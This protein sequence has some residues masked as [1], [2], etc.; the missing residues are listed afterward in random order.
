MQNRKEHTTVID[1]YGRYSSAITKA[2][3]MM[4]TLSLVGVISVCHEQRANAEVT[5]FSRDV[6]D[7]ID[8]GI[9]W[10]DS[11]GVF[12]NPAGLS[13]PD[14]NALGLAALSIM[15]R[16]V[17]ADQNAA[18]AGYGNATAED[19]VR[20]QSLIT[21]IINRATNASF[22]AYRDGGDL[23]AI[24]LYARTGGPSQADAITAIN[25]I[26]DRMRS[27]QGSHGY[28]AYSGPGTDSSTTQ[29]VVAGLAGARAVFSDQRF[30]DPVRLG[31]LNTMTSTTANAY[32]TRSTAGDLTNDGRG[33]GYSPTHAPSFQQTASGLWSQIIG[34]YDLNSQSVQ[35][36]LKWL[37]LRYNYQTIEPYRNSWP[38]AHL[39]YM[40]SSAKAYTFLED[41]GA[42]AA[43]GNLDTQDLGTLPSN[44]A[45][46]A[47]VR[48][49]HRDPSAD[50]RVTRRGPEGAGYY[51]SIHELPR[52]YYDYAYTLMGLQDVNGRFV[53]NLNSW[54]RIA[55][56]SYA[57]L[58]LERSVGGGCVDSDNDDACDA[59]DNC[60]ALPN[61]DQLDADNDGIGDLCDA[62]PQN[63]DPN[64]FDTDGDGQ[65]DACDVCPDLPNPDQEDVDG[66]GVGDLCDNCPAEADRSQADQDSDGFGDVCD[67]CPEVADPN[68]A[69][70]D[71][72]G[73]GNACDLCIA[74]PDPSQS[75]LDED[76]VGDVCDNCLLVS[77]TDQIDDDRD[78]VGD[79]CDMCVGSSGPEICDGID[80]DC[81]NIVDEDPLLSARC[82]VPGGGSCGVGIP[83]CVD[84]G[85]ICE[86]LTTAQDELC[87]GLDDDCDGR[88]DEM[89]IDEGQ[90]CF[91]DQPGSCST[92]LSRCVDGELACDPAGSPSDEVCDLIDSD[93]DGFIDEGT[94]NQCGLCGDSLA[95]VCDGLDQDCDGVVD[96]SAPCEGNL[97][98]FA[99]ECVNTCDSNECFGA[100]VCVDGFCVDP[101]QTTECNADQVCRGGECIDPCEEVTCADNEACYLG[102]CRRDSCFEI[103]CPEG[104]RCGPAGC[105]ND[106]CAEVVC[107][108]NSFCRD[109]VCIDSCGIISCP[110]DEQCVDGQCV[111]NPCSDIVCGAGEECI[112]GSC[113]ESPCDDVSCEEGYVCV[114][115][116]CEF[117]GC[118]NIECPPGERCEI[119]VDGDA[120][121]VGDWTDPPP[122]EEL[123]PPIGNGGAEEAGMETGEPTSDNEFT[124]D[125]PPVDELE[126]MGEGGAESVSGCQQSHSP[127]LPALFLALGIA[128]IVIRR[129]SEIL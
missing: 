47:N 34:G 54:N 77:N 67:V 14:R 72:D 60:P 11:I 13:G 6:S 12:N 58:V 129:R 80:N 119:N 66:D 24:S 16:R 117:N 20:I 125:I 89:T 122:P 37:Y 31:Q 7:A 57:M 118:E 18:S 4:L 3:S 79:A 26:F 25:N 78:G 101:C 107:E 123:E 86:P 65:G 56:H 52:W 32:A 21:Y 64:Q 55:S 108:A 43:P 116:D 95:E 30:V 48:L 15:E 27:G 85:V 84:G 23:M 75:D 99:G 93:C 45:P 97:T 105:E 70:G 102:E 39:Y 5:N 36:Y 35:E 50:P 51:N 17:S 33:H 112:N 62:C 19:Q 109:G 59:E 88:L 41:S 121:C 42:V 46:S 83:R 114:Y 8:D 76:G 22:S 98:C 127:T 44:A 92:G 38:Q 81:D 82:E 100:E 61:P 87:N 29:L 96:E 9:S 73:V 49:L 28:W 115:G 103:P 124:Q 126:E 2:L 69:D 106:P 90:R 68:Q 1:S 40:W 104:Q 111:G 10:L 128:L 110:G 63:P 94:R 53:S 113:T 91:T 74:V 120:Q 71:Q